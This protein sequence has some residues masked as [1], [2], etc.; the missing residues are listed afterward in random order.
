M[1]YY[2]TASYSR[3]SIQDGG[4]ETE[5]NSIVNQKALVQG[6][7]K[8]HREF[9][10]IEEYV[11]DGYSGVHFDRPGFMKMMNDIGQGKIQCIIVK[12][13]SRFGRNYTEVG[14]FLEEIFPALGVRFISLG[15]NYDSAAYVPG[16][17]GLMIPILNLMN[18]IY[19]K[20]IS[21]KIRASI[22]V[23][24][25][26][27]AFIGA[28]APYGY[29]R[30]KEK[31]YQLQVDEEAAYIVKRIFH[32]SLE[33][34]TKTQIANQL[35]RE[36]ILSPFAYKREKGEQFMTGFIYDDETKW[37]AIAVKRILTNR[38]YLGI[39]EQ[40]KTYSVN[41]KWRERLLRQKEDWACVENA[42][43]PIVTEA[44]FDRVQ[45][46]EALDRRTR[47]EST[48]LLSGLLYCKECGERL[49]RRK[50]TKGEKVYC[51]Y[52]CYDKNKKLKHGVSVKEEELENALLQLGM[53]YND[54]MD[55]VSPIEQRKKEYVTRVQ[56]S[57]KK[58]EAELQRYENLLEHLK[59][60]EGEAEKQLVVVSESKVQQMKEQRKE[61][62]KQE[63]GMLA[64]K[65]FWEY[66][67]LFFF[68]VE[69]IVISCQG[70]V[71]I[72]FYGKGFC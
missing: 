26:M 25:E 44:V 18:D 49:H 35:N 70:E 9:R 22:Q 16:R 3:L 59:R 45:E 41:Y 68:L 2:L 23:K 5:S 12:D 57:I 67:G 30:V 10:L 34:M 1:K 43:Q 21:E 31:P 17:D 7:I 58:K 42:H 20:D 65:S 64:K 39:L 32:L 29:Q 62:K 69:K 56:E 61:L 53:V 33:G 6:Y 24:Q 37:Y 55:M 46:L 63:Q 60:E 4:R 66:R 27:G 11:D 38:V 13:L 40:G 19:V 52:G 47:G 72:Y 54:I 71:E 28:F 51:Y 48:Y 36:G 8:R 14:R 15:E 50:K